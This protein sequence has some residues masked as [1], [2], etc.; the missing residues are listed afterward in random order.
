MRQWSRPR[1]TDPFISLSLERGSEP[2][3]EP[4]WLSY[5]SPETPRGS[6]FILLAQPR[7]LHDRGAVVALSPSANSP[8]WAN[9]HIS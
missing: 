7:W 4:R 3:L 5:S 2:L 6:L 9:V 1:A 8:C